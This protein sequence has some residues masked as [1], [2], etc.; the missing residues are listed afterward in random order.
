M[1]WRFHDGPGGGSVTADRLAA[2]LVK[3]KLPCIG[4]LYADERGVEFLID[5]KQRTLREWRAQR[6]GPPATELRRWVYDL[7][8]L[9]DWINAKSNRR[10]P[11]PRGGKRRQPAASDIDSARAARAESNR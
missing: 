7:V 9:A 4:G 5:V 3:A 2:A 6:K 11:A 10:Q 8:D 1:R